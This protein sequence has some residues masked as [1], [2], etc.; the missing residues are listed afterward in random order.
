[1]NRKILGPEKAAILLMDLGEEK[2]AQ[3]LE[4]LDDREVQTLSNYMSTLSNLDV[5]IMDSVNKDFYALLESGTTKLGRSGREFFK[6]SLRQVKG[7]TKANEILKNI[8]STEHELGSGLETIRRLEPKVIASF[9]ENEHPQT[10]AIILAH[11]EPEVASQTVKEIA[12]NKR[13]EIVHRLATLEKVS[14][15]VLKDLDEALQIEFKYSEAITENK[16]GGKAVAARLMGSMDKATESMILSS[17]DE[18]DP[19]MANE[20]RKLRFKFEDIQNID[21]EGIQ[22]LLKEVTSEDLL[23]ALKTASDELKIKL[24]TNMS[25][26]VANMLQEDLESLG[27]TKISEVE[28]A[29]QKFVS[30]CR[31]L[32]ENGTI[33]LSRGEAL[34]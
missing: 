3:V 26:R 2:A 1:M 11:L 15:K 20:I 4:I 14:P 27:P 22:L 21:D 17:I 8:N 9:I 19:E 32:E 18:I 13:A 6:S 12:E 28:K 25:D 16:L 5:K 31:Q 29:Q 10:A 23:V 30:I 24:F 33:T 34:V 7:S